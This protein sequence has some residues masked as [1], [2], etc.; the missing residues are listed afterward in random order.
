MKL[1]VGRNMGIA[2]RYARRMTEISLSKSAYLNLYSG[3]YRTNKDARALLVHRRTKIG[4]GKN[5]AV[6]NT[7]RFEIGA[8]WPLCKHFST[9][10][11][12][13][14]NARLIV[15]GDFTIYTGCAVYVNENATLE[16]GSGYINNNVNIHCFTSIRIGHDVAIAEDVT[17]RD[18]DTHH[19]LYSGYESTQP[20]DIGDHVWIGT[21]AIILKGVK[22]GNGSIIAAGAV[23]T[24]NVPENSL[25]GGVPARII[26][27]HICWE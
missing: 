2:K 1:G 8:T 26:K 27:R 14:N 5:I 22:I 11:K 15:T 17:I 21:R 13:G 12:I 6:V 7:G 20:I 18:S 25:V 19:I 10:L 3:A 24:R 16:L 23:V 9:M 4:L